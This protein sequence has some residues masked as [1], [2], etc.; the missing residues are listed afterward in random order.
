MKKSQAALEFLTTYAWAFVGILIALGALYYF[1]VFDFSKYLPEKCVFT[2]QLECSDFVIE[3]NQIKIRLINNL[4]ETIDVGATDI[5]DNSNPALSCTNPT[6]SGWLAGD[7]WDI[8]FTGCAGGG[9]TRKERMEAKVSITYSAPA[10]NP[11][12]P[13]QHVIIGKLYGRVK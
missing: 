4:G 10:T 5:T 1:G 8:V 9:L 2:S 7:K 6:K 3:E 11:P 13:P 12:S